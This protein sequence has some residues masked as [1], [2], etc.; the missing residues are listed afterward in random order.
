MALSLSLGSGYSDPTHKANP[1]ENI[2]PPIQQKK[3]FPKQLR[4]VLNS[5]DARE[6]VGS[7]PLTNSY[8]F[9]NVTIPEGVIQETTLGHASE[10][11]IL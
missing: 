5:V 1:F 7:A 11:R 8:Y 2:V 4:L 3:P 10:R 9:T 6:V